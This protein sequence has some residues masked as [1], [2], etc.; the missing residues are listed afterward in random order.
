[1]HNK[2][3]Y[4]RAV[5]RLAADDGLVYWN[6]ADTSRIDLAWIFTEHDEVGQHSLFDL[7][8][9]V[10]LKRRVGASNR[11]EWQ[12]LFDRD[13]FLQRVRLPTSG[14]L[15]DAYFNALQRLE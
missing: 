12:C 15:S 8:L 13:R 2:W 7:A 4:L 9:L 1:V 6:L 11:V 5:H 10:L 3:D 14:A